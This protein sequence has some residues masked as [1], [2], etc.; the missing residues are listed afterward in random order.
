MALAH[1][2]KIITDGLVLCLDAGNTKSYP[3]SG[4]TWSDLSGNGNNG[5]LT[6]MDGANLDSANG[7]SLTFDGT[8][9]EVSVDIGNSLVKDFTLE[10]WMKSDATV[11][12]RG[13]V[14]YGGSTYAIIAAYRLKTNSTQFYFGTTGATN[15]L[16]LTSV[17]LA[18]NNWHYIV[19]SYD[20]TN[21]KVYVD[22]NEELTDNSTFSGNLRSTSNTEINIGR[23][24]ASGLFQDMSISSVKVYNRALTASEIKQNF[25]ALRGR[26]SI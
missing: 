5:T 4:T 26:F 13:A 17:N 9:E 24:T 23:W 15:A 1:S 14:A 10:F 12:G 22:G 3:G 2:P 16:T 6:N 7:G 8:N 19:Q 11:E 18:D 25:N 20:G 21:A